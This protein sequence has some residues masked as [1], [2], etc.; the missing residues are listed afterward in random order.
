MGKRS[1]FLISLM[2]IAAIII[3]GCSNKNGNESSKETAGGASETSQAA[4]NIEPKVAAEGNNEAFTIRL[5]GWFIDDR[6]FMQE[7]KS[8]V[9]KKYKEK[10]PNATIQWDILLGSTYFDRLKA[11]LASNTAPDVFFHQNTVNQY[12]EVKYLVDLSDQPWVSKLSPGSRP[13]TTVDGKIYG[14]TLGLSGSGVWYNKQIFK[15]LGL[16]IPT[17]YDE[18]LAL[19]EKIKAAGTTPIVLGFKDTWTVGL[20]MSNFVSSALYG[21]DSTFAKQLYDGQKKLD[22]EEIQVVM[23]KLQNL[24]EKGY[25]NKTALSIDWPQSADEF[26]TG[27]AAM[28]VQGAWMPGAADDNFTKKGHAKFDL[29]YFQ[30]PDDNGF[31]SINLSPSETLSLNAN[32]KLQQEGKDLIAVIMSEDILGPYNVGN[33]SLPPLEG[34]EV[35]YPSTGM[36]EFLAAVNKGKTMYGFEAYISSTAETSLMETMT[37]IVSGAKYSLADLQDAQSKHDKDKAARV[38]PPE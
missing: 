6:T 24:T 7:F 32:S 21:I 28:I 11:E 15:D 16:T 27:K 5:G 25:F 12:A 26:T 29:G 19:C 3:A 33:G 34:M 20:F 30:F 4:S 2:L 8:N 14:G 1:S 36:N 23:N 37:K 31:Y 35:S 38:L 17:T 13:A 18:F 10:Y 9:E 22:G